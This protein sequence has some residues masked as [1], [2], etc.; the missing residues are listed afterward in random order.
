MDISGQLQ[1]I[2]LPTLVLWGKHDGILPVPLAQ[3]Y[4]SKLGTPAT[5]KSV[6]IFDESAHAPMTEEPAK[7][8]NQVIGFVNRYK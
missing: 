5:Q 1:A 8:A 6:V 3:D 4:Y 7:F 2:T